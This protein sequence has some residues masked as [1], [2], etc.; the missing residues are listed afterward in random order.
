MS[1]DLIPHLL[2]CTGVVIYF[3]LELKKKTI[4]NVKV[5]LSALQRKQNFYYFYKQDEK[6]ANTSAALAGVFLYSTKGTHHIL[7]KHANSVRIWST[8]RNRD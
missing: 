8:T 3:H 2:R 4:R 5:V 6:L 1:K 7:C